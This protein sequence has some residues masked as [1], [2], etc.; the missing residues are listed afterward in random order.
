MAFRA[1]TEKREVAPLMGIRL[2]RLSATA[3]GIAA[4]LAVVAGVFLTTFPSPG[5][6]V[7]L[8]TVVLR[9]F[10]AAIIGGLD[11]VHGAIVGGV[12]V[13]VAEVLAQG[14]QGH[15]EFLGAGFHEVLTYAIMVAVL[16]V[17]PAGL[18][19]SVA[20]NRA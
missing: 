10:P 11:S 18:F 15:L 13:G 2:S 3:W 1:A 5:V 9:A 20:V 4:V 17:R 14:Y 19:G 8:S 7:E 16:L 6:S 12:I